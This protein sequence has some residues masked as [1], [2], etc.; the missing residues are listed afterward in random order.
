M[1]VEIGKIE[2]LVY[3]Y[4][5]ENKTLLQERTEY[6]DPGAS[7]SGLIRQVLEESAREVISEL[8]AD[9]LRDCE[10]SVPTGYALIRDG[11]GT[12]RLPDN[13]SRFI[14]L[15]MSGWTRGVSALLD[16]AGEEYSL[17]FSPSGGMGYRKSGA[18]ALIECGGGPVLE[19]FGVYAG[20]YVVELAYVAEPSI[21]GDYITV[22][23]GAVTDVAR[24]VADM[25]REVLGDR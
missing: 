10:R 17:R 14:Y 2:D 23:E 9:R 5:N 3:G 22:P 7:V 6:V 1:R 15:R 20:D 24:K 25:V 13:F 18:A 21:D 11:Y 8:P 12:L 4:L 16:P 19:I